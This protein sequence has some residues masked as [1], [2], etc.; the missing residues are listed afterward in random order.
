MDNLFF[1]C[2]QFCHL[3]V[4]ANVQFEVDLKASIE[5]YRAKL[6]R[7]KIIFPRCESINV[8][9][10]LVLKWLPLRVWLQ[11][12]SKQTHINSYKEACDDL[13]WHDVPTANHKAPSNQ[14]VKLSLLMM[15]HMPFSGLIKKFKKKT[16]YTSCLATGLTGVNFPPV[17]ANTRWCLPLPQKT[18]LIDCE[19]PHPSGTLWNAYSR[20]CLI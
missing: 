2:F 1:C 6:L 18:G 10:T 7:R 8:T 17:I 20:C 19:N 3:E 14:G 13:Y 11:V 12:L 4:W 15:S 16:C 9:H 5:H